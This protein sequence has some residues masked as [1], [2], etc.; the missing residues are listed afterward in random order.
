MSPAYCA[1]RPPGQSSSV[2]QSW[3]VVNGLSLVGLGPVV[4]V[5]GGELAAWF[6]GLSPTL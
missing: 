2:T 1:H 3:H 4:V 5:V 6:G